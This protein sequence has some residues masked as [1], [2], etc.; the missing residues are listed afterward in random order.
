M[1][2][3]A[4]PLFDHHCHALREASAPL[5]AAAFRMYFTESRDPVLAPHLPFSLFYARGLRDLAAL[6]GCEPE[7]EAVLAARHS[8]PLEK[9]ARLLIEAANIRV[10]LV[11]SGLRADE[12]YSV[13]EMRDFL[14]CDVHEVLR[15]ET[16]IEQLIL[17]TASCD[18]LEE[19][20]RAAL[21][22][23]RSL[24]F[25]AF[26]SIAAYRGGLEIR[27]RRRTEAAC[28]YSFCKD[29]AERDGR[30]R[31]THRPLLEYLLRIA[32]EEAAAQ[33]VPV[34][35]HTGL[36]DTDAD[37]RAANPL[38]LR[39]LLEDEAL[40]GTKFVLLHTWPYAREAGY[41]AGV[42]GNIYVDLSL[43]VPFTAHGGSAAIR[44][45]LEQAPVSKVL[46]ATDAYGLP[47]R[48]YLSALYARTCLA[49]A[50]EGLTAE[51]WLTPDQAEQA[52]QRILYENAAGLYPMPAA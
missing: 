23:A 32:L 44:A 18:E 6:L 15:L 16:L 41:L 39:P 9:H 4:V 34:Q 8:L 10:M 5:D 31:L 27:P 48:F 45:A 28:F 26:K 7:E 20:Y 47:E 11:D 49:E 21:A 1:D 17:E 13:V 12:N 3:T 40:R 22:S 33:E 52:A 19:A 51:G 30:V 46:L 50:L 42:Y 38:H 37:L 24:G 43:T 29:E 35:F 2:L 36:G 25:A 14:P